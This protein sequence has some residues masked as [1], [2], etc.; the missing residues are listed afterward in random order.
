MR[1]P[2]I[3]YLSPLDLTQRFHLP[4]VG[5]ALAISL[6]RSAAHC[7]LVELAR[8][9]SVP[10]TPC[11][12]H[13]AWQTIDDSGISSPLS[14]LQRRRS[15]RRFEIRRIR[16]VGIVR[17]SFGDRPKRSDS[18]PHFRARL[19]VDLPLSVYISHSRQPAPLT[20][21]SG[22]S[23]PLPCRAMTPMAR[24]ARCA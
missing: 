11:S 23:M 24:S 18:P 3:L 20:P 6:G 19:L 21:P 15:L 17:Y 12:W 4:P 14:G 8:V 16:P 9:F 1:Q 5:K 2:R 7:V 10:L 13:R 22:R